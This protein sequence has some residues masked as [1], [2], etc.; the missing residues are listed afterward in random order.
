MSKEKHKQIDL[1]IFPDLNR[2]QMCLVAMKGQKN[3]FGKYNYRNCSDILHALKPHLMGCTIL[4][5]DNIV[6]VGDRYYVQAT[7]TIT[8]GI[9]SHSVTAF[10]RECLSKKG[11]DESQITGAASSYARKYAL[12]G[13]LA[14][15]DTADADSMDNYIPK[16]SKAE[17]AQDKINYNLSLLSETLLND[18]TYMKEALDAGDDA[19][20]YEKWMAIGSNENQILVWFCFGSKERAYMKKSFKVEKARLVEAAQCDVGDDNARTYI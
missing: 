15:D 20:V 14:I 5:T 17:I 7:A 1:G 13:L 18:Y 4:L 2:I 19:V 11:M 3:D 6:M 12:N 16:K 8:N 9:S 10:A